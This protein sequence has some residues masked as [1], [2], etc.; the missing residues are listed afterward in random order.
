[1]ADT[2][3]RVQRPPIRRLLHIA[4]AASVIFLLV[5]LASHCLPVVWTGVGIGAGLDGGILAVE[6][7]DP[8]DSELAAWREPGWLFGHNDFAMF[9]WF[10][11]R[12]YPS[13]HVVELHLWIPL[14]ACVAAAIALIALH[15][16]RR[17]PPGCCPFCRYDLRGLPVLEDAI[18][19]P[20]CG[21]A[22]QASRAG[23]TAKIPAADQ[24]R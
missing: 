7:W 1:M 8:A 4:L 11:W 12:D 20:E 5:D 16:F 24:R 3:S 6:W 10:G 18:A 2:C 22:A 21:A 19:C 9:G 13:Y 15:R 23:C 14:A 17:A